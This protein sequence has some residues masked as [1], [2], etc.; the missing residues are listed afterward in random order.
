MRPHYFD[1]TSNIIFCSTKVYNDTENRY[2]NHIVLYNT[3]NDTVQLID[4]FFA[5]SNV[6]WTSYNSFTRYNDLLF[7]R[8]G[9]KIWK[10]NFN[11]QTFDLVLNVVNLDGFD[12]IGD[13]LIYYTPGIAHFMD[14]NANQVIT[15]YNAAYLDA[16]HL[17]D[18]DI[19][20]Y[21]ADFGFSS[22]V[23]QLVKYNISTN[24][25]E[26]LFSNY[27][28]TSYSLIRKSDVVKLNE[29]L[30]YTISTAYGVGSYVSLDLTSNTINSSFTFNE[31]SH[32]QIT[33]PF[34]ID[35]QVFLTIDDDTYSSNGIDPPIL[36]SLGKFEGPELIAPSSYYNNEFYRVV[37][38]DNFGPEIWKTDGQTT[39]LLKDIAPGTDAGMYQGGYSS[40]GGFVHNNKIYF[41]SGQNI[42][43]E[44]DG[45]QAGTLPLYDS[46]LFT[47]VNITI[48]H[49]NTNGIY[50][51]GE[52][53][54]LGNGMFKLT[55]NA[56]SVDEF[57][58]N[59]IVVR[60]Y[61][62]PATNTINFNRAVKNV[63]I[64]DMHGKIILTANDTRNL[65]IKQLSS[66]SIYII[67]YTYEDKIYNKKLIISSK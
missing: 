28:S 5:T 48:F 53:P 45:T 61:P 64:F 46:D 19:Y 47:L 49:D 65:N 23:Y 59:L 9:K 31:S 56:L 25:F 39:S 10:Y 60:F 37:S 13:I 21:E 38:T 6:D 2:E 57:E 62:N 3:V 66:N 8:F 55:G 1:N 40:T 14:L 18:D 7:F 54:T 29:N 12:I 58:S 33:K 35:D 24:S 17:E 26:T 22:K 42:I 32:F 44:S 4:S 52:S 34:V 27:F 41:V 51:F 36:T 50:F 16:F 15:T 11:T 43:Y 63:K 67:K 20:F 30:I